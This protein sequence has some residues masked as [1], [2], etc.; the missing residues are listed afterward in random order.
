MRRILAL[1]DCDLTSLLSLNWGDVEIVHSS[2]VSQGVFHLFDR[3]P[4]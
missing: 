2:L 3:R 4:K 1:I